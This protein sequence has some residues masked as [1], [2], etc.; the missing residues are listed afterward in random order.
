VYGQTY[1]PS[2]DT[3]YT[4]GEKVQ[5]ES[6]KRVE[7]MGSYANYVPSDDI[8]EQKMQKLMSLANKQVA[9]KRCD[10]E[11][12]KT[13]KDWG[14]AKSRY[15][16]DI[17]RKTENM[18]FGSNFG[19]R[20]FIRKTKSKK[21]DFQRNHL[22]ESDGSSLLS[23]SEIEEMERKN[24]PI[25]AEG[26]GEGDQEPSQEASQMDNPYVSRQDSAEAPLNNLTRQRP[27]TVGRAGRKPVMPRLV[28]TSRERGEKL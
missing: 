22:D 26:E 19:A 12:K 5:Y 3:F 17:Q 20:A 6:M 4:T 25:E 28:D 9:E 16:E 11:L 15:E 1:R 7:S 24:N 18:W 14:D 2:F 23:D 8:V 10:D 21:I 27:Q 13:M